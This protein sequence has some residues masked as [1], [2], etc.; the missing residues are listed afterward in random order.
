MRGS[1]WSE[2]KASGPCP[3]SSARK[4]PLTL[5]R[6]LDGRDR[7]E[8]LRSEAGEDF[9]EAAHTVLRLCENVLKKRTEE[10]CRKLRL[11]KDTLHQKCTRFAMAREILISAGF[12][13]EDEDTLHMKVFRMIVCEGGGGVVGSDALRCRFILPAWQV[14]DEDK[15]RRISHVLREEGAA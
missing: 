10:R 11:S 13:Q 12:A 7:I 2:P 1:G 15:L 4:G 3:G 9:Q 5:T 8:R 14:V 6:T